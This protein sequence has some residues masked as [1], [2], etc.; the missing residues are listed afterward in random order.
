LLPKSSLAFSYCLFDNYYN[1]VGGTQTIYLNSVANSHKKINIDV[2]TKNYTNYY[3]SS[4]NQ[5]SSIVPIAGIKNI[6]NTFSIG[7]AKSEKG[8]LSLKV[9]KRL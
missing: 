1:S 3:L 7:Q 5:L 8:V 9:S 2:T 6:G 4:Q